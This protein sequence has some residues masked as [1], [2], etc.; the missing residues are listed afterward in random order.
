MITRTK[1]GINFQNTNGQEMMEII[2]SNIL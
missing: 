2:A 1:L